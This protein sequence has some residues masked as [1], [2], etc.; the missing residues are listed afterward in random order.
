MITYRFRLK[1]GHQAKW[2]KSIAGKV[3]HAW[4]LTQDLRLSHKKE[5]DAWLRYEEL[6]KRISVDGLNSQVTQNVVREYTRKCFQFKK[7]KLRWRTGKKNLG[8]I[9][10]TNQNV[11]LDT[12]NGNFKFMRRDFRIWYSRPIIGKIMTIS[13]NEDSR[14][15]WYINV[16]CENS[17]QREHGERAVG[18]DLGCKTQIVCSDEVKYSRENLTKKYQ[19]RMAKAQRANKKKLTKTIHAKIKNKRRDWNH[20]TTTEICRTSGF[21]AVGDISTKGLMKTRMAKSLSDASHAQIKTMLLYK[22]IRHGMVC[23]IVSEKFSTVTCSNCSARSGPSGLSG[24]GVR[25]WECSEC[26]IIHDRDV[27]AARNILLSAQ[28]IVPR[29]RESH[30]L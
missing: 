28:D 22:A 2:L 17:E 5:K 11:K 24:L 27:N 6:Q 8:W 14:G 13:L 19:D 20:K 10:C 30:A 21:V 16:V 25:Q 29:L 7:P 1:D 3:N 9:P 18:I 15:R 23:K 12:T 4:N 26:G